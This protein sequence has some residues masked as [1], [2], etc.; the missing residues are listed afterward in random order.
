MSLFNIRK[1]NTIR[2]AITGSVF[3]LTILS[4]VLSAIPAKAASPRSLVGYWKFDEPSNTA[5]LDSSGYSHAGE[6]KTYSAVLPTKTAGKIGN[7]VQFNGER[8]FVQIPGHADFEA[9]NEVTLATWVNLSSHR[10]IGKFVTKYGSYE[11][12]QGL[13]GAGSVRLAIWRARLNE[14]FWLDSETYP[15]TL[16]TWHWVVGTYNGTDLKIYVDGSLI[17]SANAPGVINNIPGQPITFGGDVLN[18]DTRWTNGRLDE[19]AIWNYALSQSEITQIYQNY[20]NGTGL[21]GSSSAAP[22]TDNDGIPDSSDNCRL[23]YNPNQL[24]T[25][26]DGL[27]D[28]CDQNNNTSFTDSDGDGIADRY[29]NCRLVWNANQADSDTDGIGDV[30][31]TSNIFISGIND[32]TLATAQCV[33]NIDNISYSANAYPRPSKLYSIPDKTHV[34]AI[35]K[36]FRH[37]IPTPS[38]F[39]SYGYSWGNVINTSR[40]NVMKYPE[41]RFVKL[42]EGNK[43][44]LLSSKQWLR[45]AVPS[46]AVFESYGYEW[47]NILTISPA[48]LAFYPEARL[49]KAEGKPAVYLAECG[50]KKLITSEAAFE[51][52]GFDWNDIMVVSEAQVMSYPFAGTID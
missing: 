18:Q 19:T 13:G 12:A 43:V 47:K 40:W 50:T 5:V 46:P 52:A 16:N 23:V 41:A 4:L 48:D 38:I 21:A 17:A 30:C 44:Y 2:K 6:L 24:D 9:V 49:I 14:W 33:E 42:P 26:R 29:D 32:S 31:D 51:R 11:L 7:A 36:G 34:W 39:A 22:D 20:S 25:D 45:K 8:D 35:F 15:L 10:A 28:V 1:G 3:L 27:G 37:P